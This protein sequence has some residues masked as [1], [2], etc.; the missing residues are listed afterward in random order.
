MCVLSCASL[1]L[2]RSNQYAFHMCF[3]AQA[4]FVGGIFT[5]FS[6]NSDGNYV[7]D[8]GGLRSISAAQIAID[9][10]NNKS[11]GVY[12]NLLPNT[13]VRYAIYTLICFNICYNVDCAINPTVSL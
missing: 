5:Q 2:I 3:F 13:Q 4:L 10:V 11:D 7:I 6:R 1:V 8:Q 12:D 9:R